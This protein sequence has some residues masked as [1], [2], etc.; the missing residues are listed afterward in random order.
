MPPS[1]GVTHFTAALFVTT[2]NAARLLNTSS[3]QQGS[4]E[5]EWSRY[6]RTHT[7]THTRTHTHT[8]TPNTVTCSS[9]SVPATVQP[10][11]MHENYALNFPGCHL[12]AKVCGLR[13]EVLREKG[14]LT[15]TAH[16]N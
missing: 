16:V 5:I 3:V 8:H 2:Q 7:H 9:P 10:V 12:Q 6:T 4:A 1:N 13:E 15:P 14:R 11:L